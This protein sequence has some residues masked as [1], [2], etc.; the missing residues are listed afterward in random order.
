MLIKGSVKKGW[1]VITSVMDHNS[2]LRALHTLSENNIIELDIV[3]A[4]KEGF[5]NIEELK[6]KIK[7][8]TK[9]IVLSHASN[10]S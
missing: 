10:I 1:H 9:L 7:N 2:T 8:N 6:N 3:G 5:I 4:S